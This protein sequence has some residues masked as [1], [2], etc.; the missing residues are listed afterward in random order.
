MNK[1]DDIQRRASAARDLLAEIDYYWDK[2]MSIAMNNQ[3]GET[4]RK[5]HS[6]T[7]I[8]REGFKA[9]LQEIANRT[10]DD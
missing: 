10:S 2:R 8:D 6:L 4:E 5:G 3:R 9:T 1:A 7:L